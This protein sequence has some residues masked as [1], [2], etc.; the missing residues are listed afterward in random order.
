MHLC[1]SNAYQIVFI[2]INSE[3]KLNINL[4]TTLI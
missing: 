1:L 4:K 2:I 3:N